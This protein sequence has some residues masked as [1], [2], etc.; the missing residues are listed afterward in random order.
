MMIFKFQ[1]WNISG[2][3]IS[4]QIK[5]IEPQIFADTI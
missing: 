5:K 1:D 2:L 4:P 3:I